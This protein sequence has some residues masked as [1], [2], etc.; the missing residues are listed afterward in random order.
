[1]QGCELEGQTTAA[2]RVLHGANP[3]ITGTNV[4][5]ATG[6]GLEFDERAHGLFEDGEVT[7][8]SGPLVKISGG[9]HP[10]L[11]RCRLSG[12]GDDGLVVKGDGGATVV[13]TEVREMARHGV[14]VAS[15]T[16]ALRSCKLLANRRAGAS[17]GTK[18]EMEL[19]RCE[20]GGNGSH[21]LMLLGA[22]RAKLIACKVTGNHKEGVSVDDGSAVTARDNDLRGNDGGSW[23]VGPGC[24]VESHGNVD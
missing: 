6:A 5:D 1:V 8:C 24:T 11:V 20:V 18:A 22:S 23:S 2:V 16:V 3:T 9:A 10:R 21:G 4:R 12:G 19:E 13:D 15:G 14:S 7:G 17:L